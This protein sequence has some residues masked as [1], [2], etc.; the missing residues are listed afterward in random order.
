MP[1]PVYCSN[2]NFC[3]QLDFHQ[4]SNNSSDF[5]MAF[6]RLLGVHSGI[7]CSPHPPIQGSVNS[8]LINLEMEAYIVLFEVRL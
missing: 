6:I 5:S 1:G 7:L 4:C 8:H 2:R 3:L